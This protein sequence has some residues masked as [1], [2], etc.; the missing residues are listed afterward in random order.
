MI[1]IGKRNQIYA[2]YV[3]ILKNPE[4]EK[5][6]YIVLSKDQEMETKYVK[7]FDKMFGGMD[8]ILTI[9]KLER[10]KKEAEQKEVSEEDHFKVNSEKDTGE[11]QDSPFW[12]ID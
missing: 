10:K 8:V 6:I 3:R 4:N 9:T 2:Q 5:E 7:Q 12:S 1:R 11:I